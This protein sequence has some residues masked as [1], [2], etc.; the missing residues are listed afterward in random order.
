MRGQDLGG[1]RGCNGHGVRFSALDVMR[2]VPKRCTECNG[3]GVASANGSPPPA[4]SSASV[5]DA[6]NAAPDAEAPPPAE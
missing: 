6:R 2:T 4:D 1:C 3:T 5:E